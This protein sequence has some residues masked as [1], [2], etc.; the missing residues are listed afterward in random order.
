ML[1][2]SCQTNIHPFQIF[3]ENCYVRFYTEI[4]YPQHWACVPRGGGWVGGC[5]PGD[6]AYS[7]SR[8][9]RH[10]VRLHPGFKLDIP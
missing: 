8:K 2:M 4:N 9:S 3:S 6:S 10:P 5:Q 7:G 1:Q